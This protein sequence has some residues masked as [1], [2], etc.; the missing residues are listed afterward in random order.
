MGSEMCIRDR[1]KSLLC[2]LTFLSVRV[3]RNNSAFKALLCKMFASF[4][5]PR[6]LLRIVHLRSIIG[7]GLRQKANSYNSSLKL[8]IGNNK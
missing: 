4:L 1:F 8:G 2:S 5:G 6:T 3:N 7:M